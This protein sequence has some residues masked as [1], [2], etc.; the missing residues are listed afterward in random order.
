MR[1]PKT[2]CCII[3][4]CYLGSQ[5]R[6]SVEDSDLPLVAAEGKATEAA[7]RRSCLIPFGRWSI[8]AVYRKG[9]HIGWGAN[10]LEHHSDFE[11]GLACQ[12]SFAFAGCSSEECRAFA[13][14]WLLMGNHISKSVRHGKLKHITMI[15][16][17]DIPEKAESDLELEANM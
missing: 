8:S 7:A 6:A 1:G 14:Q 3:L 17:K 2:E 10:C 12:R 15:Q 9:V 16:R 13:K 11:P 4:A 5:D